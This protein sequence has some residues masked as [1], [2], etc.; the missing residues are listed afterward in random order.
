MTLTG[1]WVVNGRRASSFG[2]KRATEPFLIVFIRH[3]IISVAAVVTHF[4]KRYNCSVLHMSWR[5]LRSTSPQRCVA[6]ASQRGATSSPVLYVA[7]LDVNRQHG[8]VA[9]NSLHT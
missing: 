8:G 6:F 7:R 3:T 9:R 1:A 4:L 2:I 5:L